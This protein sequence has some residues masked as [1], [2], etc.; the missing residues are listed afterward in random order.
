MPHVIELSH[1]DAMPQVT[2]TP[3]VPPLGDD[4]RA[5]RP[6]RHLMLLDDREMLL[7]RACVVLVDERSGAA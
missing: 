1:N 5:H 4:L 3:S 6:D 2:G 7:A